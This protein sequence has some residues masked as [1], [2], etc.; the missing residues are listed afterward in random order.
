V[1]HDGELEG[2]RTRM[3]VFLGRGQDVATTW[4]PHPLRGFREASRS[5]EPYG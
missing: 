5:R 3:P 2:R 1:Y 4:P